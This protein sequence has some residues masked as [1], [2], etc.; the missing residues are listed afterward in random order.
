MSDDTPADVDRVDRLGRRIGRLEVEH[1]RTQRQVNQLAAELRAHR[2]RSLSRRVL[3]K[4]RRIPASVRRRR[5]LR[6]MKRRAAADKP[7]VDPGERARREAVIDA[8]IAET[9][10]ITCGDT[11]LDVRCAA[12]IDAYSLA[13]ATGVHTREELEAA[14]PDHLLDDLS[15]TEHLLQLFRTDPVA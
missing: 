8:F 13:V 6:T 4:V 11:P 15:D 2:H 9:E 1:D 5:R 3:G 7:S 12:A 10:S 14:S